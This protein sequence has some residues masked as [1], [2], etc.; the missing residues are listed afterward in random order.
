MEQRGRG[1]VADRAVWANLV[2]VSTPSLAL[3][4]R[5]VQVHEP[6][7]RQTLRAELAVE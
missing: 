2:V 5:V 6:M 3:L 4:L 1:F 7:C